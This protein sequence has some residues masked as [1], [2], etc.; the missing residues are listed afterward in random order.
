MS[1]EYW[2]ASW[3]WQQ[4]YLFSKSSISALGPSQPPI[5]GVPGVLS[6][7]EGGEGQWGRTVKLTTHLH[8]APSFK[9]QWNCISTPPYAFAACIGTAFLTYNL[10]C[11]YGWFTFSSKRPYR[12][13]GP[14]VFL[15]WV[16]VSVSRGKGGRGVKL[17]SATYA[18]VACPVSGFPL[19]TIW[20]G[21]YGL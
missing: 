11:R 19:F 15:Q 5:H 14:Y 1:E 13:W 2:F 21:S 7:E 9:D 10:V 8:P 16:P 4:I 12:F 18:F 20:K 6:E 3:A 17:V